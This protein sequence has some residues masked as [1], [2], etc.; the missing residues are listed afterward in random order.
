MTNAL[1]CHFWTASKT[2][3]GQIWN[4]TDTS[5]IAYKKCE[6]NN[7]LNDFWEMIVRERLKRVLNY[8]AGWSLF[9]YQNV[10]ANKNLKS[11][12]ALCYNFSQVT[13]LPTQ[14]S[15]QTIPI[16]NGQKYFFLFSCHALVFAIKHFDNLHWFWP[17]T[18]DDLDCDSVVILLYLEVAVGKL[19][20]YLE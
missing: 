12:I 3:F 4:I 8:I 2:S 10:L 11:Q 7:N 14:S 19:E 6:N 5:I 15:I 9:R 18:F 17:L 20:Q 13:Y 1:L 16:L